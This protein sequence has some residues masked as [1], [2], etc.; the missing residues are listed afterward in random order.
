M[1][2]HTDRCT[3]SCLASDRSC[4]APISRI[5]FSSCR[6]PSACPC[7]HRLAALILEPAESLAEESRPQVSLYRTSPWLAGP[8]DPFLLDLHHPSSRPCRPSCRPCRI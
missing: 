7:V 3:V 2:P 6:L 1:R 4:G 5:A 8:L